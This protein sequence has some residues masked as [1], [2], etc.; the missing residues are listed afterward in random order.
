MTDDGVKSLCSDG[1]KHLTSLT[2]LTLDFR[3][4][5]NITDEGVKSLCSDEYKDSLLLY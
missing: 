5:K 2:T 1:L 3:G 4:C